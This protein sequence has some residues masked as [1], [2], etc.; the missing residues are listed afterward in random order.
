M[1]KKSAQVQQK[2]FQ[3]LSLLKDEAER[4]EMERLLEILWKQSQEIVQLRFERDKA[5]REYHDATRELFSVRR[6]R[7]K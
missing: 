2:E 1:R 5:M 7:P 4:V 6:N 3:L